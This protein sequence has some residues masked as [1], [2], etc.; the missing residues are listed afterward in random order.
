M[1]E[2]FPLYNSDKY[3]R[4][5]TEE[6]WFYKVKIRAHRTERVRMS[7]IWLLTLREK[8]K[9]TAIRKQ[10]EWKIS[11]PKGKTVNLEEIL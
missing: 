1:T 5:L 7:L 8:K 3:Q 10:T 9:L 4:C 11:G 6:R 2:R